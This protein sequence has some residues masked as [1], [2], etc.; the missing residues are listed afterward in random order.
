MQLL[1]DFFPIIAF[2][3]AYKLGGIF[4]ATAV[5]IA[6]V[7][8]QTAVQWLRHRKVSKMALI[9][10]VLVMVFG[11]LTLWIHDEMFIKWK[12]TVV[13]GLFALAFLASHYVGE[14]PLV[15]RMM[16]GIEL[17]RSQW[18]TLSWMWIG[19]FALM[20]AVNLYIAYHFDTDVWAAFKLYGTL[21]MSVA[22]VIFQAYWL[23]SR[24]PPDSADQSRP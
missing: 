7:I 17:P 12:V 10:A 18:L 3:V 4:V 22:L 11:G 24:L 2:Y 1:F 6:A 9:S 16:S 21:G 14:Q 15:Q 5:L 8:V 19:Y 23:S 20:A 13:S